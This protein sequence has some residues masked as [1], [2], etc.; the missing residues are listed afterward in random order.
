MTFALVD[1][2]EPCS[3]FNVAVFAS[4][5]GDKKDVGKKPGGTHAN[6][7]WVLH[8]VDGYFD[9]HEYSI[10]KMGNSHCIFP[11]YILPEAWPFKFVDGPEEIAA[12]FMAKYGGKDISVTARTKLRF[13]QR[14]GS[15]EL[16]VAGGKCLGVQAGD[17]S[18]PF[19]V[20]VPVDPQSESPSVEV[21]R[22]HIV[23]NSDILALATLL[24]HEGQAGV[25]CQWGR[26][27]AAEYKLLAADPSLPEPKRTHETEEE[28][29]SISKASSGKFSHGVKAETLL[30]TQS[31]EDIIVPILHACILGPVN[32]EF[33]AVLKVF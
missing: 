3:P 5:E 14:E 16:V 29:L 7:C 25:T 13:A 28:D 22:I 1:T 9:L 23:H 19:R 11:T 30:N 4:L 21:F 8:R 10:L 31:F 33:S 2:P 26:L 20:A 6:Y 17:C 12:F 18:Y 27:S 24:G 15:G 32:D